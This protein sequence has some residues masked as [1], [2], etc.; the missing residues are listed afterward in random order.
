MLTVASLVQGDVPNEWYSANPDQLVFMEKITSKSLKLTHLWNQNPTVLW[1]ELNGIYDV[2]AIS[3]WS[4]VDYVCG[5]R[6][7]Y[8]YMGKNQIG[9]LVCFI[10]DP[11]TQIFRQLHW[12]PL[13]QHTG[14]IRLTTI[15]HQQPNGHKQ[16][17]GHPQSNGVA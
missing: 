5:G 11:A 3:E 15:E 7:N 8:L 16:Y 17:N 13:P 4:Y 9:S 1:S 12:M 2:K 6:T 14:A 10:Y